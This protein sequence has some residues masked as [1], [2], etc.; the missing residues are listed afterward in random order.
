[1]TSCRLALIAPWFGPWPVWINLYLESC[2]WNPWVTWMIPTDQTPPENQ[3]PN[4]VFMPMTLA[5]FLGRGERV[6]GLR[7]QAHEAYKI[8][9]FKPLLGTMFENEIAGY[10]HYG[11]TDHDIIFGQL[12]CELTPE[13]LAEYEIISS[14][15]NLQAGHLSVFRNTPRLRASWR[16]PGW[17]RILRSPD[18][19]GFDERGFGRRLDPKKWHPPWRRYKVLWHEMY[20]MPDRFPV[21]LDGGPNP[22]QFLWQEGH[23]TEPRNAQPEYAY[24][25]FMLWRSSRYRRKGKIAPWENLGAVMHA[26]WQDAAAHGFEISTQ[27]F[28]LA[29][30][31]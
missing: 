13:R 4:V 1:M 2:R 19:Q 23:L 28:T 20:A 9:D 22:T 15:A 21:W 24:L 6:T 14:H 7:L 26:D 27:G 16:V 5:G 3:P 11:Y 12:A 25:H 30:S 31:E 8:T 18:H 17:R 29:Q 10:S